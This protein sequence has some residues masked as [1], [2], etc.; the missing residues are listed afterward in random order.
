MNII[1][2]DDTCAIWSAIESLFDG[3]ASYE[4][5]VDLLGYVQLHPLYEEGGV[6]RDEQVSCKTKSLWGKRCET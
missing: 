4:V 1:L 2:G 5:E 3:H 6:E